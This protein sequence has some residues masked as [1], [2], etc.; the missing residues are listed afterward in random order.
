MHPTQQ[1]PPPADQG[2]SKSYSEAECT[3][4]LF[5]KEFTGL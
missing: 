4:C 3:N 1:I 5:S 2:D